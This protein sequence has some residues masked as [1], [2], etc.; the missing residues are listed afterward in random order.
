MI[1]SRVASGSRQHF[2]LRLIAAFKVAKG[3][4][5]LGVGGALLF[6]DIRDTWLEEIVER[7]NDELLL[8]H[9]HFVL[10]ALQH[11]QDFLASTK[12]GAIGALALVYAAVL[13]TEG[14][15]VW[16]EKHW[17]EWLMVIAT[18]SLIPFEIV[19]LAR[20]PTITR[21]GII[22]ANVAIVIYLILVLRRNRE[23]RLATP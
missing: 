22:I 8:V 12:L 3:V 13:M 10:L 19:H 11:I 18:A 5:L 17:A 7:V 15:G 9:N 14:I 16:F 2:Y 6:L 4:L 23:R 20:H 21:V 1:A